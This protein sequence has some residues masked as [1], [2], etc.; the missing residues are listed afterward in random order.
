M[1]CSWEIYDL[2][3]KAGWDIHEKIM[4]GFM[5]VEAVC[6]ETGGVCMETEGVSMDRQ[7]VSRDRENR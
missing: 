6:M 4:C 3:I 2:C 5:E 7:I 1:V